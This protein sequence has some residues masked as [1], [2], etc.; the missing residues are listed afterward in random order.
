LPVIAR[1]D[2]FGY[3]ASKFV[4]RHKAGVAAALLIVLTL[5][6]GVIATLWQAHVASVQ[7]ARAEQRFNDVR[8]LA[9][10]C[11]FEIHDSVQNLAGSTPTRQLL[12]TRALEY[13]DSLARESGDDPT[14]QSELATAYSRV[15]DIQGNPYTE[16]L[17]DTEG[18]LV[19][20]G[21]AMAIRESLNRA[22]AGQ[23][24]QKALGLSYRSIADV[25][26]LKG[27]LAGSVENYRRS[28]ETF[29]QLNAAY[30]GD[31]GIRDELARAY[32][33]LG[34]GLRRANDLNAS[35]QCYRQTLAIRDDLLRREPANTR[36]QLNVA[37]SL[38][39]I[40][41]GWVIDKTEGLDSY[42]RSVAML[43]ALTT[44]DQTNARAQRVLSM[45]ESRLGDALMTTGDHHGAI[46]ALSKVLL[47]REK[48]SEAD[49]QNTQALFD[50]ATS[51]AH[52]ADVFSQSGQAAQG[53]QLGLKALAELQSLVSLD[54]TDLIFLRNL[55][56]CYSVV[57]Q[58]QSALA[59]ISQ[60]PA[61]ARLQQ[62]KEARDL[63][64]KALSIFT[65]LQQRGALRPADSDEMT[66][67][68]G[69]IA[70]C[71]EAM[72]PLRRQ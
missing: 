32:E 28:L 36:L 44:A 5:V 64:Q 50:L 43:E 24:T 17:G 48:L 71:E 35:L 42:R 62:W 63:Y 53:K 38:M 3:R 30:S 19:S 12:V 11:L 46:E 56:L 14:L 72:R 8:R 47:I 25:L 10:S 54:A 1:K 31:T 66:E 27:D 69:S 26:D 41:D 4:R 45:A 7:R 61:S 23:E 68:A 52:L 55:G 13:L 37:I 21:K 70:A 9:N 60:A 33:S 22:G 29:E 40:G 2:T 59:S 51:Q 15:G 57:A 20:Y 65:D 34:D 6:A 58:A 67:M 49:P 16:N 39:K 18:A